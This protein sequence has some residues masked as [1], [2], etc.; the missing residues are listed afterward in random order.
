MKPGRTDGWIHV[1]PWEV[2]MCACVRAC[3]CP[4]VIAHLDNHRGD[5]RAGDSVGIQVF[6]FRYFTTNSRLQPGASPAGGV[7]EPYRSF[8]L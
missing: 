7:G 1:S 2:S 4:L 3:V 6:I 8:S 5:V